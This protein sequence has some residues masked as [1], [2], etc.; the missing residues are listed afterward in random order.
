MQSRIWAGKNL[1]V[2]RAVSGFQ[3]LAFGRAVGGFAAALFQR[4]EGRC[5]LRGRAALDLSG[6]AVQTVCIPPF[7]C[8]EGWRTRAVMAATRARSR[9]PSGMTKQNWRGWP[10]ASHPLLRK[11][12]G[13][14]L[15]VGGFAGALFPRPGGR[16]SSGVELRSIETAINCEFEA[17]VEWLLSHGHIRCTVL[18]IA[19]A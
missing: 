18:Q 3:R 7:R 12:W 15:A 9:F 11:G 6:P 2:V 16:C 13:T 17:S 4:P 1:L 14:R 5:S 10:F 19:G 8:A